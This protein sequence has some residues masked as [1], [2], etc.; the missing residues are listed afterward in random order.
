MDIKKIQEISRSIIAP[1]PWKERETRFK[2]RCHHTFGGRKGC[3]IYTI[4]YLIFQL[5]S[6]KKTYAL[7]TQIP[8]CQK[9][10]GRGNSFGKTA[11]LRHIMTMG[12]PPPIRQRDFKREGKNLYRG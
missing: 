9:L 3:S 8:K 10:K 11:P 12:P 7:R 1:A 6:I 2:K 4:Y 5:I